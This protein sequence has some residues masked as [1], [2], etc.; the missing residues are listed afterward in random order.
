MISRGSYEYQI[1]FSRILVWANIQPA[2]DS[3]QDSLKSSNKYISPRDT[4]IELA[5]IIDEST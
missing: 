3:G 4:D 5:T 2:Q 1:P